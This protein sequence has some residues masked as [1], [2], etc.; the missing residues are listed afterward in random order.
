MMELSLN[1][2]AAP[3]G[4]RGIVLASVPSQGDAITCISYS[5]IT[6]AKNS[7]LGPRGVAISKQGMQRLSSAGASK[8]QYAPTS[9]GKRLNAALMAEE[10]IEA[11]LG[12]IS[13][14]S[15][16]ATQ[17]EMS[18]AGSGRGEGSRDFFDAADELAP[19]QAVAEFAQQRCALFK[20]SLLQAAVAAVV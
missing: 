13:E 20:L 9:F 3:L 8:A 10:N 19:A 5:A 1:G 14:A 11:R 17:R 16:V 6:A 7:Q 18:A 15:G 12:S 4:S 2:K